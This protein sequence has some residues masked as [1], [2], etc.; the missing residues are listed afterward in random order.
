MQRREVLFVAS[1]TLAIAGCIDDETEPEPDTEPEEETEEEPEEETEEEPEEETEEEPEEETEEEP[2]EETEEP[3]PA[4]FEVIDLSVEPSQT[5]PGESVTVTATVENKGETEG[6]E[7]LQFVIDG[8]AVDGETIGDTTF[9]EITEGE[10]VTEQVT[11]PPEESSTVSISITRELVGTFGVSVAD[12]SANFEVVRDWN[13]IG[14]SYEGAG[15][16]TV[17]LESFE[18]NEKTGSYE[19]AIDYT[20]E[21]ETDSSI[22]EGAFQLYPTDPDNDPLQQFGGFDELFP[23]DSVSRSYTFEE[24]KDIEHPSLVK[25]HTSVV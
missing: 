8:E 19:Y 7:E 21:N 10:T 1:G 16:L 25:P 9:E 11:V 3:A 4:E 2:E 13:E 18:V 12:L 24:E 22:D 5:G 15:G 14:D 17:T 6:T 23:N 20:L